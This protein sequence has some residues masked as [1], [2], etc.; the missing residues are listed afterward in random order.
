MATGRLAPPAIPALDR[1]SGRIPALPYPPSKSRQYKPG[2]IKSRKNRL[3]KTPLH[4]IN[5]D[6]R[7]NCDGPNLLMLS[8]AFIHAGSDA[9]NTRRRA[10]TE[11]VKN[12][13]GR[14][15][16]VSTDF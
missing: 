4:G 6:F 13:T 14:F 7:F 11:W 10:D 9:R 12:K 2:G 1:R 3:Q 8:D 5:P 15:S 16:Y